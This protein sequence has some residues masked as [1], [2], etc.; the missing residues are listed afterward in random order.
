MSHTPFSLMA[1]VRILLS[2]R[3]KKR[4]IIVTGDIVT[5]DDSHT[6][7]PSSSSLFFSTPQHKPFSYIFLTSQIP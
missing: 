4:V 7:D 5:G 3:D 6:L 1:S 2:L